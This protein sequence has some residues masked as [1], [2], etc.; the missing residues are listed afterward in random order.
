VRPNRSKG[1]TSLGAASGQ[2]AMFETLIQSS[3]VGL[4]HAYGV[5]AAP[6]TPVEVPFAQFRPHY[7]LAVIGFRTQGMDAA[8][9]VSVPSE[10]CAELHLGDVRQANPREIARE[11][12]NQTMGR[13]KN[14]LSQYQVTLQCGLPV[15]VDRERDLEL[16]APQRGP[17]VVYGLRTVHQNIIIAIK[18]NV[19]PSALVY[20]ST[21]RLNGEGAIL[22]FDDT[23]SKGEGAKS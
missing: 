3:T 2:P 15:C 14:R 11:L 12:T 17:L 13:I 8:L 1:T 16:I 4:F 5:A 7:P 9:I 23:P 18:G 22:V 21:T 6:L 20:S 10:V 19:D